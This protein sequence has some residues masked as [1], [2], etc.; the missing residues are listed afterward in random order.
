MFKML[1]FFIFTL[2]THF[3]KCNITGTKIACQV[4]KHL[5]NTGCYFNSLNN[6][7]C[8]K[9]DFFALDRYTFLQLP[10]FGKMFCTCLGPSMAFYSH[11]CLSCLLFTLKLLY[12]FWCFSKQFLPVIA[13]CVYLQ[14]TLLTFNPNR[15]RLSLSSELATFIYCNATQG[16]TQPLSCLHTHTHTPDSMMFLFQQWSTWQG[17]KPNAVDLT[18]LLCSF[19]VHK[20]RRN[21]RII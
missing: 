4:W 11:G 15:P 17:T 14:S 16:V 13:A 8:P 21:S 9:S 7:L 1:G 5:N 12:W 6:W 19:F 3:C 18:L 10:V 2:H 20:L